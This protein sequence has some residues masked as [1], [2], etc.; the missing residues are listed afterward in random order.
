MNVQEL[1]AAV[2]SLPDQELAQF[3]AWF[4]EFASDAWDRQ[5]GKDAQNG[6]LDTFYQQLQG[7]NVGQADIPLVEVANQEKL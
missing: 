3:R 1:E 6:R 5:I 7:E 2:S 4:V